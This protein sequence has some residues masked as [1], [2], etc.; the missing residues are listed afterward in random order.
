MKLGLVGPSYQERSIPYDAQRTINLYPVMDQQGGKEVAAL[1]GTPGL[2][3]FSTVGLGS[4]RGLWFSVENTR[5]FAVSGTDFYEIDSSGNGTVLGS[6]NTTGSACTFA[7]NGNQLAVCDGTSLYILTFATNTFAQVSD[8]DFPGAG[9]VCFLDGYFI[10]NDPSTGQFYISA[11]FDGTSWDALDFATAEGLPD[12][13]V[14]VFATNQALLL[15]GENSTELWVNSGG[16]DFPFTR[17]GGRI[18]TGCAAAHSVVALDNTVFFVGRNDRGWGV[19]Y[20]MSGA[21]PERVSTH[22]IEEKIQALADVTVLRAW[23]YQESGHDFYVLTGGLLETTLVYDCATGLWHERAFLDDGA[24]KKHLAAT[25][26]FAFGK[27]IV[28]D[29]LSGKIY[30]M[31]ENFYDDDGDEIKRT[32]VFTHLSNEGERVIANSLQIDFERGVGLTTGQ[33][34]DPKAWIRVSRDFGRNYGNEMYASINAI[35]VTRPRAMWRRLGQFECLTIEL[36][37]S[38]PVKVAICGAYLK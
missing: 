4:I 10:V 9:S 14:R 16:G 8:V 36:N 3:L 28:G 22:F 1:Y 37:V 20:R 27:T 32:R 17:S 23:A 13:I 19:V 5:A 15:M 18:D 29:R 24:F 21:T 35:G 25:S 2:D 30:Q 26:M 7:D 38:D 34:S 33:G 11:L 6:I 31:S 12:N